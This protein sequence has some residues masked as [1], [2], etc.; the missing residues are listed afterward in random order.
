[1]QR[2]A[3]RKSANNRTRTL[4]PNVRAGRKTVLT[5]PKGHLRSSPEQRIWLDRLGWSNNGQSRDFKADGDWD[6]VAG[7]RVSGPGQT[8][9]HSGLIVITRFS[10]CQSFPIAGAMR[11]PMTE[12]QPPRLRHQMEG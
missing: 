3:S 12:I 11:A 2:A 5:A 4:R 1:M 9:C 8:A 6:I 10:R 7:D